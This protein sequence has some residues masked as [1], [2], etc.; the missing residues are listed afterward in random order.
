MRSMLKD[1]LKWAAKKSRP[2]WKVAVQK[3]AGILL[4]ISLGF[5]TVMVSSPTARATFVQWVTEWYETHIVY[6][7]LGKSTHN[8]MPQY[9]ITELPDGFAETERT[10]ISKI[11]E[12]T[13][14][15]ESGDAI[16]FNY[17]FIVQG[18]ANLYNTEDSNEFDIEV[19]HMG[20][21]FFE[22]KIPGKFNTIT[23]IDVENNLQFDI[24][25]A[26]SYINMLYIAESVSLVEMTK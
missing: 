24:V 8:E 11:M 9:E 22:S 13:Y 16:Y 23:W 12:V 15:N 4:I 7:Y 19:N 1:P 2:R 21:K 17:R 18:G 5:G 10:K 20:G 26:L 25:G 3:V 14:T 6:R